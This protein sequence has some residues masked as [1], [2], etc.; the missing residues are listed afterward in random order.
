MA[1]VHPE[2]LSRSSAMTSRAISAKGEI[3]T[4]ALMQFEKK[5]AAGT[6]GARAQ[7]KRPGKNPTSPTRLDSHCQYIRGQPLETNSMGAI[8][9][10]NVTISRQSEN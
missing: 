4:T 5:R 8:W 9:Q 6:A 2:Y 7:R 10:G 1:K 3:Q